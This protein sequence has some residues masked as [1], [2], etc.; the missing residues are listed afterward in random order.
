MNRIIAVVCLAGLTTLLS[1]QT[2]PTITL[3]A[4]P[5][6]LGLGQNTF[7]AV[8]KDSKG[9]PVADAD[10]ALV[11][12]MPAN[13][14]TK[15]PEMRVEG[16]LNHAGA[17]KYNG[18]AMVTMA[19]NWEVTAVARQHGKEIARRTERMTAVVNRSTE[20]RAAKPVPAAQHGAH[21][22][23]HADAAKLK[24]P[25]AATTESVANGAAIFAKQCAACHGATGKGDGAMAAKLKSKPAD[26]TDAEWKHGPSDG[27]IFTLIRDGA[28]NAGMKAFRGA[29]T[30]RQMWD[31]VNYI[32]SVGPGGQPR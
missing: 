4:G 25:V 31:L 12:V 29:L 20:A 5:L 1:A 10:V 26:L 8:V 27:E 17:G 11:L 24:N 7:E 3:T 32:R 15:H 18:V 23:T 19:G 6:P 16:K 13:P 22:H 9:R 30:D 14:Q 2:G 28:K 21:T